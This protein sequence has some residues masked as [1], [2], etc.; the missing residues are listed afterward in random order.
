MTSA[1]DREIGRSEVNESLAPALPRFRATELSLCVKCGNCKTL[2]PTH[3]E[4]ANEGMSARGRVV[5]LKKLISGEIEPSDTLDQRIFSCLLC[6]SCNGLCPLGISVTDA[7]YEGRR[8]LA[9]GKKRWLFR[10]IIKYVFMEPERTL[11]TLRIFENTGLLSPLSRLKPFKALRELRSRIPRT[12]LRNE[13]T[14]F[15]APNPKGRIALFAGC[16]VDFLYPAMGLSLIYTLNAL[17]YEV[18][19]PIGEVCCG[20][21]LLATGLRKEAAVLAEKNLNAFK[22]LQ[23][24]AVI[25]LCPTCTHFIKNEYPKIIGAGI[26]NAMDISQ[27]LGDEPLDSILAQP[28]ERPGTLAYHDPCHSINYLGVKE[29]PRT[30]LKGMGFGIVEPA[31]RGCCGLGGT[32]R[33]LHDDVSSAILT[34]RVKA[35]EETETPEMPEMIVTSCPN[36]VLQLESRI[37]DRPVKHI[38]EIIAANI[39]RRT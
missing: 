24:D 19:M 2:C 35:L 26:G 21:P 20:A 30:I 32:V 23:V 7:V 5:L 31:E 14:I 29:E 39:K 11:R 6:G 13:A 9:D 37:K 34:N 15:K 12:R 10:A 18:V 28:E 17:D 16:T 8:K 3:I 36:C 27:F 38:I 25:S 33:L 4:F 22:R 1:E